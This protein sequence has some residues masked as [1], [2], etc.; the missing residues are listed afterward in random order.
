M[1][2]LDDSKVPIERCG[3]PGKAWLQLRGSIL[4]YDKETWVSSSSTYIPIE[5][6]EIVRGRSI[7]LRRLWRGL[8]SLLVAILLFMPASLAFFGPFPVSTSAMIVAIG[9]TIVAAAILAV[10]LVHLVTFT[11]PRPM[12]ALAIDSTPFPL[13]I[14]FWLSVHH[15]GIQ[16][17]LLKHIAAR[18]AHL[19][20]TEDVPIRMNHMWLRPHPYR[21]ALL[22]G[23]AISLLFYLG[24]A[25]LYAYR[26]L[27]EGSSVHPAFLGLL[28]VP[29]LTYTAI[30][31]F[32]M[33]LQ[34]FGQPQEFRKAL[35][36]QRQGKLS[37]AST[38]L[39][40]LL[41]ERP[42]FDLG[43]LL[44][45]RILTEECEFEE[46]LTN[47]EHLHA[48]HPLLATRLQANLWGLRRM[49]ERMQDDGEE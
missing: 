49:H 19:Q 3:V 37:E 10:G 46:A 12:I 48:E 20:A 24:L 11:L 43:R 41:E 35:R 8:L 27:T 7:D 36:L 26:L 31:A 34:G 29:P 21:I 18:Q 9:A 32:R 40:H 33:R 6:I 2:D 25:S 17:D 38:R 13:K 1:D 5:W 14:R 4:S 45:I 22:K 44:L 47:S 30:T 42:D 23:A 28:V 16:E 39:E 15:R